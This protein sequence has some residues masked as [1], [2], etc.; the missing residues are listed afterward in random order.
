MSIAFSRQLKNLQSIAAAY[1]AESLISKK[2]LLATLSRMALPSGEKLLQYHDVLMFLAAHPAQVEE[3]NLV[4]KEFER[5][6]RNCKNSSRLNRE[7]LLNSGLPY[8]TTQ[9]HFSHDY[10]LQLLEDTSLKVHLHS[11]DEN[12]IDWNQLFRY[13]LPALERS[14]TTAGYYFEELLQVLKVEEK[15]KFSFIMDQFKGLNHQPI[16]KDEWFANLNPVVNIFASSPEYSRS[17]N[18]FRVQPIFFHQEILKKFD[19]LALLNK[20]V[21]EAINL[22]TQ[23]QEHAFKVIRYSLALTARETDP[24]TYM[25]KGTF[26]LYHLERGIS[27]AFYS[28]TADRQLPLESY[29]GYTLMKNGFPAAYGGA[30]VFG[31]RAHFGINIFEAFR[32]GESG[33]VLFQLLRTYKQVFGLKYFEVEP[34]QYGLDNPE[35]I[36]SGAF[37]FYYRYGF[38]PLNKELN[39]LAISESKKIK[40]KHG[41]RSSEKTLIRFTE[42]NIGFDMGVTQK[43]GVLQISAKVSVMIAKVYNGIRSKAIQDCKEKF[44]EI[45]ALSLPENDHQLAALVDLLLMAKVMNR[46]Q[47]ADLKPLPDLA[48]AKTTSL[49][50]YQQGLK[51]W[52]LEIV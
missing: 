14:N 42:S 34:Y 20:P 49:Y 21:S 23:E 52:L 33:Y 41:Y 9:A 46:F 5:I 31:E 17:S 26:R 16:L 50:E 27:I 32:G 29:V 19:H 25:D 8:T 45:S 48:L 7:K 1:S 43:Q 40:T 11:M 28:M 10:L 24:C 36:S 51:V 47:L 12:E 38:R 13:T 30:W 2:T 22:N 37:W 15:H 35:G 3:L 44:M 4:N 18:N 6:A 39:Q